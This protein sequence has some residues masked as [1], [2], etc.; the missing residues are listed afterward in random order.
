[1][2]HHFLQ[3][4]ILLLL[5]VGSP[6]LY[7]Q[8]CDFTLKGNVFDLH[9]NTPIFSA[10]VTIEGTTFL[11]QTDELG[12]YKIQGLCPGIYTLLIKHPKCKS[13]KRKI[14]FRSNKEI[15]FEL[16][17]HIN[18]LEEIIIS[19]SKLEVIN[20]SVKE[21]RLNTDQ[22]TQFSS[23]SLTDAINTFSGVSVLKT[24]SAIAKPLIHGMFGSRVGIVA[25]GIRLRDQEWGSDHSPNIDLNAFENV[26]VV[27]GSAALK[28]GGDTAGGIIV[29]SPY[30]LFLKDSL[31]GQTVLN[32]AS[33]GRGGGITSKIMKSTSNGYYF[34]GQLSAKR[35]G[36]LSTPEYVLSNTGMKEFNFSFKIGRSKVLR[37]WEFNYSR[38]Q[39]EAGILRAAHIGNVQDLFNALQSEF[40]LR[41]NPFTYG[42]ESPK[43]QGVHQNIQFSYFKILKNKAKWE[44]NYNYQVNQRKE[45]DVRRGLRSEIPAIDLKLKTQSLTGNYSWK[46]TFDWNFDWGINGLLE[47]NFSNPNTGIKRLIPDYFKYEL[48]S[49]FLGTYKPNNNFSWDW[50]VRLDAIYLEAQKY[51]KTSDWI[52]RG[53]D[54]QY[55][56]FEMKNLGTQILT[57][58]QARFFNF[59]A[60]TGFSSRIGPS[61]E[62]SMSYVLSQRAPNASE[63]FSDGLHH[64][65]ASIEYGNLRLQKETTHKI[66][67]SISKS[68]MAYR[69]SIEPYVS[70][71]DNYIYIAPVGLEQTIRGAFPVWQYE[72]TD[73][74]LWGIDAN[75]D[76]KFSDQFNLD[77]NAS[78]IHAEDLK[79]NL[80]LINIPPLNSSQS[81]KYTSPKKRYD[82][83]LVNHFVAKQNRFSDFNFTVNILQDGAIVKQIV[84]VSTPP[85][86]YHNLDVFFSMYLGK[87]NQSK[88]I[89]R[90]MFY[91]ITQTNYRDYLNRMRFYANEIGFN[92]QVQLVLKY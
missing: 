83:E 2:R 79:N 76:F 17:H 45:F 90:F 51:Y 10:L 20:S 22:I 46:K 31:F 75:L 44:W 66:L 13:L 40:P 14:N 92:A 11:S 4:F 15:N 18:E 39:N 16:E 47:D 28:Y 68:A 61:I 3:F 71:T 9:D 26:Q 25:N 23:R 63:L 12:N 29:L 67:T 34:K 24:G 36:D 65:L 49:Y 37:G 32:G 72:V 84:D 62:T 70:Y 38:Y 54:R 50:G 6:Q 73:A 33:N 52:D 86:A 85:E 64:S 56:E 81:I 57:N 1:M 21:S 41:I 42:V 48:G 55:P 77:I 7:S 43:Q 30:K 59:A 82:I 80:P 27:K 88:T 8:F 5:I 60:H 74:L 58:P 35:F 91:N 19:D 53:Y 69:F 78:Y 89:L 87:V